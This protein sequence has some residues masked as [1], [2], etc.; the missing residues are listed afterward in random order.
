MQGT[1]WTEVKENWGRKDRIRSGHENE[2][3]AIRTGA[4]LEPGVG[5]GR[6]H[7][8]LEGERENY[9]RTENEAVEGGRRSWCGKGQQ[10]AGVVGANERSILD[11]VK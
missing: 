11:Q 3:E 6:W 8:E 10:K 4:C 7:Q 1:T 5:H 9:C 2:R